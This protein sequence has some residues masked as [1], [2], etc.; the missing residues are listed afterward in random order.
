MRRLLHPNYTRRLGCLRNGSQDVKLHRFFAALDK[1][2][3][4]KLKVAPPFVPTVSGAMDTSNF[5]H[6]DDEPDE[7]YVDDGTGW[8]QPF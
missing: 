5:D 4:T 6:F 1:S 7:H 3:M 8:D 2:L